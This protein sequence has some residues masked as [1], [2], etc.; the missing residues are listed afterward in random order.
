MVKHAIWLEDK[1]KYILDYDYCQGEFSYS[2]TT[3]VLKSSSFDD[4]Q[5][6][7]CIRCL[8]SRKIP[9]KVKT[10]QIEVKE[11]PPFSLK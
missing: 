9:F 6:E 5:L 1:E 4:H 3:D 11:I 10:F 8:T 2:E 7:F